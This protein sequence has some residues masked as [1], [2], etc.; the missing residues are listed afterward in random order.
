[1]YGLLL[2]GNN[3]ETTLKP[4]VALQ[5]RSVRIITFSRPDEHSEPLFK[6]LNFLKLSDLVYFENAL[7][8]Y[9]FH[10]GLLPKPFEDFFKRISAIHSYNTRL[11]SKSSYYINKV[12]TNYGKF[13]IRFSAVNIW[14]TLSENVKE[15]S[16]KSFKKSLKAN[17]IELYKYSN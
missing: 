11:A 2:W 8:M 16:L 9:K 6:Q 17:L 14:N 7:F 12:R 10:N 5:K 13:N 4:I 1:M 15:L 3:Y